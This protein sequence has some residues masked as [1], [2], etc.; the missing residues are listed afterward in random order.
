M[1]L[2]AIF[3]L[4]SEVRSTRLESNGDPLALS[5]KFKTFSVRFGELGEPIA[6]QT[7]LMDFFDRLTPE[8]EQEVRQ[9][10][11]KETL[12]CAKAH[13]TIRPCFGSLKSKA[14]C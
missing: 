11:A 9:L 3:Q 4:R 7:M 1:T 6:E 10:R 13:R 2:L 14:E 8:Y 5:A 12:T